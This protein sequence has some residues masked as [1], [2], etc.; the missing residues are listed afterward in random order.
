MENAE[1]PKLLA[2]N[3]Q[4]QA[5]T[6]SFQLSPLIPPLHRDYWTTGL[7]DCWTTGLR[8][9]SFDQAVHPQSRSPVVQ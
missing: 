7:L 6:L 5:G 9:D 8:L 1:A 3:S 2:P 4:L